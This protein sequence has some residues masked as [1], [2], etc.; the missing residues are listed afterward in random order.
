MWGWIFF[1]I[2]IFSIVGIMNLQRY[3]IHNL[4]KLII[5]KIHNLEFQK[6]SSFWYNPCCHKIYYKENNSD[7]S[8]DWAMVNF[9]K[10]CCLWFVSTPFWLQLS[11]IDFFCLGMMTSFWIHLIPFWSFQYI[12]WIYRMYLKFEFHCK[13]KNWLVFNIQYHLTNLKTC[14]Y[15]KQL[16]QNSLLIQQMCYPT[17]MLVVNQCFW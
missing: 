11:L 1:L 17:R 5:F 8:Q 14:H 6:I 3:G 4:S 10:I 12:Y 2:I 13:I 7:S 16:I 15:Y 9:V